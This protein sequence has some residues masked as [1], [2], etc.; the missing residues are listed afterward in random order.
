MRSPV[1]A[2]LAALVAGLAAA[3]AMAPRKCAIVQRYPGGTDGWCRTPLGLTFQGSDPAIWPA[4][5][6]GIAAATVVGGLV[7]ALRRTRRGVGR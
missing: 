2:V 3:W 5:V 7:L 4:V 6:A 1:T